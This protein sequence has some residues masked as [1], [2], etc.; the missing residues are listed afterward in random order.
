M[1][2]EKEE[3]E[4]DKKERERKEKERMNKK[5]LCDWCIRIDANISHICS[6]ITVFVINESRGT[7][8]KIYMNHFIVITNFLPCTC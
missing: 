8:G 2:R 4:A 1:V 5:S 7:F 6:K 3:K